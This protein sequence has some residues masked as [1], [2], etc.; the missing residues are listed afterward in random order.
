[1][2]DGLDVL[3]KL[4]RFDP[5]KPTAGVTLDKITKAEVLRKRDHPY[6]PK[7]ITKK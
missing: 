2:I 4:Q 6:E 7:T 1:V 5:Q 3:S